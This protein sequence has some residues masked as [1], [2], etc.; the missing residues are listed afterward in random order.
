MCCT[1]LTLL[2]REDNQRLIVNRLARSRDMPE[3]GTNC[4]LYLENLHAKA[5]AR[6]KR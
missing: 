3:F 6:M 1:Q 2:V 4:Y 5:I